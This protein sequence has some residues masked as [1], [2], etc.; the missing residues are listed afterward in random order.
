VY[1]SR[2]GK[3]DKI[4]ITLLSFQDDE[5]VHQLSG[6]VDK[7]NGIIGVYNILPPLEEGHRS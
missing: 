7:E 1:P 6:P 2:I 3:T 5:I 4:D